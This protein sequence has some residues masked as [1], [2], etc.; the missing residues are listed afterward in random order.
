MAYSA[1][2]VSLWMI[3]DWG[4][5]LDTLEGTAAI[6][7]DLHKL[8]SVLCCDVH[9][10]ADGLAFVCCLGCSFASWFHFR[11]PSFSEDVGNKLPFSK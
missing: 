7:R 1:L 4:Q 10:R 5:T 2:S 11:Q 9:F 3:P 8:S 6:Q